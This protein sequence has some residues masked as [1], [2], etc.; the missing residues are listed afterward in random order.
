MEEF[1]KEE[2]KEAVKERDIQIATKLLKQGILSDKKIMELLGFTEKQM[3]EI[4]E[5]VLVLA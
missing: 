5:K 3:K 1:A 2:R 4:K